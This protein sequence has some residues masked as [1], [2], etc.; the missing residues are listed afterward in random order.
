MATFT[1]ELL[2]GKLHFLCSEK[3]SY[4]H[5]NI[6]TSGR[7]QMSKKNKRLNDIAQ[8]QGSLS[9]LT[10]LPKKLGFSLPKAEFWGAMYLRYGLPLK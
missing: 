2:H 10:A 8:E 4:I 7:Q 6:L 9:W 5:L 3:H 1:E